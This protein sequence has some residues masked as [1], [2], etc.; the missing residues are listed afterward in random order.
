MGL[1]LMAN[2]ALNAGGRS[3]CLA[4]KSSLRVPAPRLRRSFALPEDDVRA[5][6]NESGDF[7]HSIFRFNDAQQERPDFA[8]DGDRNPGLAIDQNEGKHRFRGELA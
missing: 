1:T 2:L 4:A 3:C 5:A 6:V 7:A 8:F